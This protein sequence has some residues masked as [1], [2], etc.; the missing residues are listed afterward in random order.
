M[1]QREIETDKNI[2]RDGTDR[3]R[4]RKKLKSD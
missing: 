2:D 4:D 1:E 3:K